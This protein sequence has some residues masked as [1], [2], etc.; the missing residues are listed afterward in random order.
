MP[1]KVKILSWRRHCSDTDRLTSNVASNIRAW[2]V[3]V[4]ARELLA[5][6]NMAL[7]NC[8]LAYL[9]DL[10]LHTKFLNVIFVC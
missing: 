5:F 3:C 8:Q 7:M 1:A 10:W 9:A 4:F 6:F 2:H